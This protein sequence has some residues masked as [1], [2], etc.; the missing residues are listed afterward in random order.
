MVV[1]I[2]GSGD[3]I[4]RYQPFLSALL[5]TLL[6]VPA[7][8]RQWTDSSGGHTVE[9]RFVEVVDG[10][11]T[12]SRADGRVVQVP[13]I[14]LSD[15]DIF[16]VADAVESRA[17]PTV[18]KAT[19]ETYAADKVGSRDDQLAANGARDLQQVG[20]AGQGASTVQLPTFSFTTATTTVTAPDGG[21]V[22]LG[23]IKRAA[24]SSTDRGVPILGKVP[25]LNRLF[26]NRGIGRET[27]S[28]MIAVTPR[29]IILEEEEAAQTGVGSVGPTAAL[30][31]PRQQ[32]ANFL[33][34][35]VGR[36]VPAQVA[37]GPAPLIADAD[38]VRRRNDAA[39]QTEAEE[40]VVFFAKAKKAEAEGK[41]GV[42]KI[43]Y[44][45]AARRTKGEFKNHIDTQ[46]AS[47]SGGSVR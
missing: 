41:K 46:I 44:Q 5:T 22:L 40:A 15:A 13:I 23:G 10:N 11:V 19:P 26:R 29:I 14:R 37:A 25:G 32:Q 6:F 4:M 3:L 34:Q 12:L 38:E 31:N 16:Y 39:K 9:A 28:K 17:R 47:L 1:E 30:P 18:G 27:S 42:A 45:M 43:F 20:A 8:A 36:A 33:A 24:E 2:F 21:T 7:F 35:N